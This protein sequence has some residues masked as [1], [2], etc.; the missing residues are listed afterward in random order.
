VQPGQPCT[1]RDVKIISVA[2]LAIMIITLALFA[3]RDTAWVLDTIPS[4]RGIG[5]S[6]RAAVRSH[7]V[8]GHTGSAGTG[9]AHVFTGPTLSMIINT[10]VG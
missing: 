1:K 5:G 9:C 7:Y 10:I 8:H 4:S 3:C 2:N 6:S